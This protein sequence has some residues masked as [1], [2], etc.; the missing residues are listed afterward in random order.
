MASSLDNGRVEKRGA[1]AQAILLIL[2][3]CLGGA[4]AIFKYFEAVSDY[5]TFS[6]LILGI[7][8][9]STLAGVA[10]CIGHYLHWITQSPKLPSRRLG[11]AVAVSGAVALMFWVVGLLSR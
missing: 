11:I 7:A 1:C 10:L 3:L 9:V 5:P 4:F 2:T 6:A 8:L